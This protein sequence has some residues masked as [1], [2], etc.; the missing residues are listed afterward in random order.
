[1]LWSATPDGAID[2][3]NTRLLDYSG[4]SADEIMGNGWTKLIHPDDVEPAARAW[5][6]CV[7]GGAPYRVEVRILH[8]A[9]SAPTDGA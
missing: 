3:C 8:A 9:D 5:M 6:S 7:A 4:F 2:Y 1:M